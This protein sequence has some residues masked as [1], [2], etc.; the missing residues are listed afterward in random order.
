[1]KGAGLSRISTFEMLTSAIFSSS[2]LNNDD[3]NNKQG[4]QD[5]RGN[6]TKNVCRR[7]KEEEEEKEGGG[8]KRNGQFAFVTFS[9][10]FILTLEQELK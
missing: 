2:K 4:D 3:F 10:S 6:I 1:V 5:A 9:S 7:V 8:E